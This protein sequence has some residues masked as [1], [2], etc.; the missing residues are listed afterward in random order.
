[1]SPLDNW[2][3]E[4]RRWLRALRAG[5]GHASERLRRAYPNAPATP[6]LRD[7][8]HALARE[9]GHAS[10]AAMKATLARQSSA[11]P[12][13][14]TLLHAAET[15][16]LET[17]IATLQAR[18][19]LLNR[20]GELR[21]HTGAR[22][23]LHFGVAREPIVRAL[24]ERGADPNIRDEGDDAMPLHFAAERGDLAVVTLLIEHGADPIGGETVHL[25]DAVGWAV[26]F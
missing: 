3:K 8:Q 25:L 2:R 20:R 6:V 23:A 21:G 5:D 17:L 1:M 15:G 18:P 26:C 4:A 12:A 10:W 19:D 16:D 11:D 7:V 13:L 24:L 14:Q 9:R 22:T